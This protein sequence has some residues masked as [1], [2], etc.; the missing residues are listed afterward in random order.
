MPNNKIR[1]AF[2]Q[3]EL[4]EL[5]ASLGARAGMIRDEAAILDKAI[6]RCTLLMSLQDRIMEAVQKNG[7]ESKEESNV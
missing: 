5:Y 4:I 1:L 6:P 3:D 7:N 2:T